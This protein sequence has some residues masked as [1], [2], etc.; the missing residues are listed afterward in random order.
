MY[1]SG[2]Q[3]Q[4]Q[5]VMVYRDA[6]CRSS[7]PE[8]PDPNRIFSGTKDENSTIGIYCKFPAAATAG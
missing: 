5:C 2:V 7:A 1:R 3:M 6:S 8:L 4:K